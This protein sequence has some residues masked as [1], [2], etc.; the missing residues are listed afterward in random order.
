MTVF[1]GVTVCGLARNI[2]QFARPAKETTTTSSALPRTGLIVI[3]PQFDWA[4]QFS[5]GL[6]QVRIG[7]GLR[8]RM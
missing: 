6:A 1:R 7:A 5:E 4:G 2:A 8:I 3:N